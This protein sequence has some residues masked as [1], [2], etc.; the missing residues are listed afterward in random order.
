MK[1]TVCLYVEG[2][3]FDSARRGFDSA[4]GR[5]ADPILY[6]PE[7]GLKRA[8]TLA[9]LYPGKKIYCFTCTAEASCVP[10]PVEI[11]PYNGGNIVCN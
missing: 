8:K 1:D 9:R 10:S 4:I 5:I 2:R 6:K 3:G 7:E 11:T